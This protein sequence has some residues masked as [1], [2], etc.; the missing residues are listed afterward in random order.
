MTQAMLTGWLRA[1]YPPQS[2]TVY[3]PRAKPVPD[4]VEM[5]TNWPEQAPRAV[6]LGFKPQLLSTLA[7]AMQALAG[8]ETTVISILGGV[9]LAR[10]SEA[11]PRA[12]SI[13]RFM[14]NLAVALNLS[15]IL[16]AGRVSEDITARITNLADA[17]GHA[18]W[19]ADEADYDAATALAGSG[20]AFIYRIID[21]FAEAGSRL[22]LDDELA[23]RLALQMVHGAAVLAAGADRSPARLA[24]AVASPNGMTRRGLDVLDDRDALV[25]LL[26]E[27][28][29]A[30]RDRGAEMAA[31]ASADG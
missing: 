3:N 20:P 29:R 30:T 4:G 1:G 12:G 22:G 10:L 5:V 28:L 2:F 16:L 11:F 27:T 23:A 9:G 25:E 7:A 15:P 14:P 6:V 21:G 8:Q 26:T 24:D 19:I 18:E 13:V 17:L 31:E